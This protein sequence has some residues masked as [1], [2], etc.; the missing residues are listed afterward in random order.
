MPEHA[1]NGLNR[2]GFLKR[3]AP[4]LILPVLFF[5]LVAR[6]NSA[7]APSYSAGMQDPDY[8]YLFSGLS[9]SRLRVPQHVDNPGTPVQ[10]TSAIAMRLWHLKNCA[11]QEKCGGYVD[12]VLLAPEQVLKWSSRAILLLSTF[13]LALCGLVLVWRGFGPLTVFL[14]QSGFWF[15]TPAVYYWGRV[16]PE[17]FMI[18]PAA[19][20]VAVLALHLRPKV[21]RS[22]DPKKLALVQG[23]V[24]GFGL[25]TKLVFL[26]LAL[27]V[28][29]FSRWR[30]RFLCGLATLVSFAVFAAPVLFHMRYFLNWVTQLAGGTHVDSKL[31]PASDV[32]ESVLLASPDIYK[33]LFVLGSFCL[34]SVVFE[35]RNRARNISLLPSRVFGVLFL[36]LFVQLLLVT[37]RPNI[38]YF[39]APMLVVLPFLILT[40]IRFSASLWKTG[41]RSARV[42]AV[43]LLATT[44][45]YFASLG[46]GRVL[47]LYSMADLFREDRTEQMKLLETYGNGEC[48]LVGFYTSTLPTYA[49]AYG[50]SYDGKRYS[51]DLQRLYPDA[52]QYNESGKAGFS[53]FGKLIDDDQIRQSMKQGQCFMLYGNRGRIAEGE[54]FMRNMR[55]RHLASTSNAGIYQLLELKKEN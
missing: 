55:L 15:F 18:I 50:N 29:F 28:F 2:M 41:Q 7:R 10:L 23:L 39:I 1:N 37:R 38:N 30:D 32:I 6:L 52:I 12:E 31:P 19:L 48:R 49:L 22:I 16:T 21:G 54:N 13:A 35:W 46:W 34:V 53:N 51:L 33:A 11:T 3:F 8:L 17:G 25:A 44:V 47:T 14:V 5:V 26:P 27:T 9:L 43:L 45:F 40:V 20:L 4:A 24:L 36:V 42:G